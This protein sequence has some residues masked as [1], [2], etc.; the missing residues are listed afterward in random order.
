[1]KKLIALAAVGL[2]AATAHAQ[3]PAA[4]PKIAGFDVAALDRTANACTDFYQFACGGWMKANP[5]PADRARWGRFDELQDRNRDV[6]R[7]ILNQISASSGGRTPVDQRIGDHYAACMDESGAEAKGAKPLER[8]PRGDRGDRRQGRPHRA[9]G[10]PADARARRRS[11]ATGRCRTSRTR[12]RCWR[13]WTR[14]GWACPT[15]TTT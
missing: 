13:S 8:G 2:A 12:P 10:A 1:M 9:G 11:S 3:D 15:A 5:V 7:D 6:L 4:K 14:A